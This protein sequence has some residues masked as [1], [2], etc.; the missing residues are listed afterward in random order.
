MKRLL[1]LIPLL[2]VFLIISCVKD[3][4]KVE[5]CT[6]VFNGVIPDGESLNFIILGDQGKGDSNQ[7]WVAELMDNYAANH[8]V[9]A[10]IGTG[11]NIY[12]HGVESIEDTMFQSH[13]EDK[14]DLPNL[15]FPF[16]LSL[17]NHD[18]QGNYQA[19]IDYTELSDK[20][21][22]PDLYYNH[23]HTTSSGM[24]VEFFAID[25]YVAFY[26][27][28]NKNQFD[29]L[30]EQLAQSTARWK[31]VYG[32]H[33]ILSHGVYSTDHFLLEKILPLLQKYDVDFYLAGHEHHLEFMKPLEN[34]NTWF[35]ISG[36]GSSLRTSRC[37]ESTLYNQAAFGF[38]TIEF[39]E[40][41]ALVKAFVTDQKDPQTFEYLVEKQA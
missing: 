9:E 2:T 29:W 17:G 16:Y 24:E 5:I 19:Q 40:S 22:M 26:E 31:I 38:F 18:H 3:K 41:A 14:Y 34:R 36:A 21:V 8:K 13:F 37:G 11:D 23:S 33:P 12:P 20:W 27:T 25:T 28:T 35:M 1:F 6:D 7:N 30:E 32:H 10:L 39:F 15:D 4:G